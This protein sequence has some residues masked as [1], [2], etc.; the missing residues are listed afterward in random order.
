MEEETSIQEENTREKETE[1]SADELDML[2]TRVTE[3]EGL[4]NEK[5]KQIAVLQQSYNEAG[6]QQ[7]E[8]NNR[9]LSAVNSYKTLIA[10]ANADIPAELLSGENIE[11][12]DTSLKNARTLVGKIRQGME[13][14][15]STARIPGGAP[16]RGELDISGLSPIEKIKYAMEK[17]K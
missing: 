1:S 17:N 13:T 2:K 9:L 3:L 6:R 15:S 8:M 7:K 14:E 11:A 4:A 5:D 16:V 12:I 10:K